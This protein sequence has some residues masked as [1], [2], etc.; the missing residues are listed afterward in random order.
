MCAIG[1]AWIAARQAA[2]GQWQMTQPALAARFAPAGGA[3]LA[4]L[5]QARIIASG[6]AVDPEA[7]A[8]IARSMRSAPGSATP[9]ML[10]GLAA[11][12]DGNAARA[13]T[14]MTIA[15][16]RDPRADIARYWL[17]DHHVRRGDYRAALA[18]VGPAM[19][20]RPGT[21]EAIVALIAALLDDPR[22]ADA[23]RAAL[24][25]D[26]DW[27][28]DF[29]AARGGAGTDPLALLA[30]LTHLPRA[31]DPIAADI[32]QRA[33]LRAAV[34]QRH[35]LPA[36]RAWRR[37]VP[38]EYR[39]ASNAPYDPNFAG[40]PGPLPFNWTTGDS[41]AGE[42]NFTP[43]PNLP[44]GSAMTL[45]F[46]GAAQAVLT[47]QLVLASPGPATLA[48]RARMTGA[49]PVGRIVARVRCAHDDMLLSETPLAT[50]GTPIQ[51]YSASFTIPPRCEA[52]RLQFAGEPGERF[53]E[54]RVQVTG[55]DLRTGRAPA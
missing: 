55:V 21:R 43:A 8:L 15:R 45:A 47:E 34:E 25:T 33:V 46:H 40:L 14:L 50:V 35:Y 1:L 49:E 18:E 13:R 16:D 24:A 52:V 9:M 44:E 10:A 32:E 19:R 17:L 4:N 22:G 12:A 29:F 39:S 37:F 7:R 36:Y 6:G 20:L 30:L 3:A 54:V 28:S 41:A 5:A 27:R 23:V 51:L 26:P 31:R 42:A 2:I 48:L 53:G 38:P 11:S